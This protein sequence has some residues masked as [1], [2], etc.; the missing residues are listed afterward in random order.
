MAEI[1]TIAVAADVANWRAVGFT[2]DD[3]QFCRV[4]RVRLALAEPGKGLPWWSVRGLGPG[5]IDGIDTRR[6]DDEAIAPVSHPNGVTHIDHLV[7]MTPHPDETVAAIVDRGLDLRRRYEEGERAFH[8]FRMDE[9]VLEVIGP[10]PG[11]TRLWGLAFTTAD[12]HACAARLGGLLG[13]IRPAR[14]PGRYIA[15]VRKEA[16]LAAGV[17]FMSPGAAAA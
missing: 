3:E 1:D 13:P 16:G 14:Q 9:V 4:G 12:L 17:A 8:F 10:S 11:P 15:S 6:G 2:V 5:P 7:V